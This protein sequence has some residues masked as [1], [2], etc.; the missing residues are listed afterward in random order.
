[1]YGLAHGIT[2]FAANQ[3]HIGSGH[4]ATTAD[5]RFLFDTANQTLY[6]DADGSA[7]TDTAVAVAVLQGVVTLDISDF[8]FF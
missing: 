2:V 7:L 5:Q 6:F 8:L 3:L 4:T 1:M